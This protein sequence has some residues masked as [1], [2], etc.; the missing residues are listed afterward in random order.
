MA[1]KTVS[2][3]VR[4]ATRKPTGLPAKPASKGAVMAK[5]D[6]P[7][8][9][10]ARPAG[11]V[12]P[13]A[14][15]PAAAP[16]KAPSK[17]APVAAAPAVPPA[18]LAELDAAKKEIAALTAK[19]AKAAAKAPT[20]TVE[21]AEADREALPAKD[22]RRGCAGYVIGLRTFT[23]RN[24]VLTVDENGPVI[25]CLVAVPRDEDKRGAASRNGG[26]VAIFDGLRR[27]GTYDAPPCAYLTQEELTAVWPE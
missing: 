8:K 17:G 5:L 1:Q 24:D 20:I 21:A 11:A 9:G 14:A 3:P 26:L 2:A 4:P 18:V 22:W 25:P 7:A 6:A 16:S 23:M 13:V 12:R 27:D 10:P 19:L 15:A